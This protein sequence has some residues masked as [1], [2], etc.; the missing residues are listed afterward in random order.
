MR[1]DEVTYERRNGELL[2]GPTGVWREFADHRAEPRHPISLAF[3]DRY[4]WIEPTS[5]E[6][7]TEVG[8]VLVKI[9]KGWQYVDGFGVSK[10]SLDAERRAKVADVLAR[11][12]VSATVIL[13][14]KGG[15]AF[16]VHSAYDFLIASAGSMFRAGMS[17]RRC[18]VCEEWFG[19]TRSDALTCGGACRL[20]KLKEDRANG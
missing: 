1:I 10:P 9:T 7:W 17:M 19:M 4:P 11:H 2:R 15:Y 3:L 12:P 16:R 8:K 5:A 20:R 13:P 18:V 14:P 6:R